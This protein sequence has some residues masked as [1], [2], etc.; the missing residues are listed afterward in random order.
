MSLWQGLQESIA[1]NTAGW[2]GACL[3]L[4]VVWLLAI[5]LLL[6][7]TRSLSKRLRQ[8]TAGASGVSLERVLV[9]HLARVE[10]VDT[11]QEKMEQRVAAL[12]GQIPLCVQRVGLVRYDAFEDV[13]GQ[14][15][16]SLAMLDA[17]QNGIVLT[18]VYTRSDVRVYAKAIRQGQPS[19]PLSDEEQQAIRRA[20]SPGGGGN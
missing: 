13:G 9:D 1:H 14:Q 19:H 3:L 16:F 6:G 4:Q 8:L 12:E 15:S 17:Q 18:S 2:V 7:R 5:V 10:E 11:R 20:L